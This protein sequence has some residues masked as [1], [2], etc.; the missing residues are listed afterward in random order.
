MYLDSIGILDTNTWTWSIPEAAGISPSRRSYA[1]GGLLS[2][3]LLTVAFGE[4]FFPSQY[5]YCIY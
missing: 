5:V 2:G 1:S 4:F 3:N